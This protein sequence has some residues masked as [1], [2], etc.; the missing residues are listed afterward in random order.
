MERKDKIR[1]SI[2]ALHLGYGGIEKAICGIANIFAEKPEEYSVKIYSVYRKQE[3]PAFQLSSSVEVEY[4][5]ED[6]PNREEFKNAVSHFNI[7]K[8]ISEGLKAFSI[9]IKKRSKVVRTIKNIDSG[10]IITTRTEHNILLSQYGRDGVM[11][12]GQL[13]QDHRFSKNFLLPFRYRYRNLDCFTVLTPGLAEEIKDYSAG[14]NE[15]TKIVYVPNFLEYYPEFDFNRKEKTIITAGRLVPVK[16]TAEIL[17]I[18]N[19]FYKTHG[20]WKLKIAGDGPEA[21]RLHKIADSLEAKNNILFLGRLSGED[22]IN[23]MCRASVFAMTSS[24][25][26][27]AFV[28]VE[29]QSCGLPT[30]AY[31][32]RVGPAHILSDGVN[33]FVVPENDRRSFAA[34]L[35]Q[36]ADNP[37]IMS[38]MSEEARINALRFSK[39]EIGGIW[40][41]IVGE[42]FERSGK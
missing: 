21:D 15:K 5:L 35:S 23:E 26:G 42:F 17:Y 19:E 28:I 36:I 18:F 11:K 6:L 7:I 29:G 10:V 32:V 34:R 12:I 3:K 2:I 4:L 40:Y 27:F 22:V 16:N 8:V 41:Q 31:D 39:N 24:N 33:G 14:Y 37:I 38:R 20:D 1:I 30:V 25:E 9:I 13:H